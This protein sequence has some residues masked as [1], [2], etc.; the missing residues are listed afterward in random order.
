M[1]GDDAPEAENG[2]RQS[3]KNAS[4]D[5]SSDHAP[6]APLGSLRRAHAIDNGMLKLLE[7]YAEQMPGF[8]DMNGATRAIRNVAAKADDS[9]SLTSAVSPGANRR[10]GKEFQ[11]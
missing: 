4:R 7:A 3:W 9:V 10:L 11:A 2:G 6:F 1:R 8:P 5:T